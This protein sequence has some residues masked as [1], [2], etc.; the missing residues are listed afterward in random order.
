MKIAFTTELPLEGFTR[1]AGH[2]LYAPFEEAEVLVSTFDVKVPRETIEAMPR[3]R[4]I[5]NFG[6][7]Y[8][9][10]DLEVCKERGIRVTNTP[11]P[12]VEPTAEL[13][14]A[15]MIDVARRVSEFDRMVRQGKAQFGGQRFGEMEVWTL[16]AYGAATTLRLR[17]LRE[18]LPRERRPAAL[19]S[20]CSA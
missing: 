17:C 16:E 14:F 20:L 19:I 10:I 11:Q 18:Q 1:L 3:L 13:A 12:V 9:N 6:A 4:L 5:A 7:G 8:N 15:L 2:Q